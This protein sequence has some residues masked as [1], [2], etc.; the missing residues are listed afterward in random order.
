MASAGPAPMPASWR[1]CRSGVYVEQESRR[2][3][4]TPTGE[5]VNDLLVE[6]FPDVLSVDFTANMED[7]L[8]RIAEGKSTWVP[9]IDSFYQKFD[10]R[11][12]SA[13]EAIPKQKIQTEPGICGAGLSQMWPA[14]RFP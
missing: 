9:V 8:D 7:D 11:L 2:L 4:P 5:L 3:Y 12:K 10:Q 1:R 6:H 13:D 14:A